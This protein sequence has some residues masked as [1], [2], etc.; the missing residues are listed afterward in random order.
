MFI[1]GRGVMYS[2]RSYK[3]LTGAGRSNDRVLSELKRIA[4]RWEKTLGEPFD[5]QSGAARLFGTLYRGS[6]AR[7]PVVLFGR[8]ATD[9]KSLARVGVGVAWRDCFSSAHGGSV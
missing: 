1:Q 9:G 7:V 3:D 4:D 2:V 5:R 6:E 8:R